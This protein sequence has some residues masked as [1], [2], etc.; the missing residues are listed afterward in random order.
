MYRYILALLCIGMS[1][2]IYID[3]MCRLFFVRCVNVCIVYT[4]DTYF[5]I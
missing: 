3:Y 5:S 2:I 4:S 1:I